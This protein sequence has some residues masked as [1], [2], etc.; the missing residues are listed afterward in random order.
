MFGLCMWDR[1]TSMV[2]ADIVD[3]LRLM[4]MAYFIF[5]SQIRDVGRGFVRVR[6]YGLSPDCIASRLLLSRVRRYAPLLLGAEK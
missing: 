6:E 2:V 1:C 3:R 5:C 4:L